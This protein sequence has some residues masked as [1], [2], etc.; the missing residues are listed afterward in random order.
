MQQ[1][2]ELKRF[3]LEKNMFDFFSFLK[4]FYKGIP[5]NGIASKLGWKPKWF[6]LWLA[7]WTSQGLTADLVLVAISASHLARNTDAKWQTQK[8]KR[9]T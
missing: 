1:G 3:S 2:L 4:A 7:W 6:T 5:S 9:E 8:I